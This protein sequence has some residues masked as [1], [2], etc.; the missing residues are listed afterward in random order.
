MQLHTFGNLDEMR[1]SHQR[2]FSNNIT[3]IDCSKI[4]KFSELANKLTPSPLRWAKDNRSGV[5][6]FFF[7][8]QILPNIQRS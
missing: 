8:K 1:N 7:C 4:E 3:K 6:C 5:F 2:G